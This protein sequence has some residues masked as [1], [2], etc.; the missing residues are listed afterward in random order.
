MIH[1]ESQVD[2]LSVA[3][4]PIERAVREALAQTHG[5]GDVTVVLT[6]DTKMRELNRSY[7]GVDETTDVLSFPAEEKDPDT[8]ENYLGD[9]VVSLPQAQVQAGIA[10]HPL[11]A[12]V[13]LLVI[14]GVLHLVGHDHAE[15]QDRERMWAAQAAALEGLG[16]SG[17]VTGE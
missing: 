1:I 12:E 7:V 16:L 4:E 17:I 14:H 8:G 11:E 3:P 5:R 2:P 15:A 9:V 6:D 13:Q 10:G